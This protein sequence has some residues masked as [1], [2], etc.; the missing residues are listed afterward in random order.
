MPA[1]ADQRPAQLSDRALNRALL[2]RQHLLERT[3]LPIPLL[4]RQLVGLQAQTPHSWYLGLWSRLNGFQPAV[5]AEL[6]ANRTLVRTVLM[7]STLHLVTARDC[8]TLRPLV[9]IVSERSF[10]SNW[11]KQLP[12]IDR[13]A[14]TA[15]GRTIVEAAPQTNAALGQ[16]LAAQWP[17]YPPGALAMAIR[18]WV[19]LVQVPPRGLWGQ[20]GPIAHTSAEAWLGAPLDDN[21]SLPELVRRYLGAFGPATVKDMQVWSGLSRL[22]PLFDTLRPYLTTF[23][24]RAGQELFDL[25][26][27]PRP[28]PD[29]P[30][31][32]RFLYDF[33]NIFLS[34]ADRQRVFTP[35]GQRQRQN[36]AN[37][38]IQ[39]SHML[40]DGFTAGDWRIERRRDTATLLVTPYT[41]LSASDRA[42]LTTEGASLLACTDPAAHHAIEF[43]QP[44]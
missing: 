20:S 31:P 4:V 5:A 44:A 3:T 24:N 22:Q 14:V 40:L 34:H 39:P 38:G 41:P 16:A 7:R 1:G 33:D 9:Q 25:P 13:D 36:H 12:G 11:L 43:N 6:L 2:A 42:S 17:A 10:Q 37:N 26:D 15:A 29:T 32:A 23:R 30:A 19:P 8:L 35:A 21:P 27:A 28:D 18:V